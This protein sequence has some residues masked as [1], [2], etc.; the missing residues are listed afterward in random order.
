MSV[1]AAI[2]FSLYFNATSLWCCRDV[3]EKGCTEAVYS[4]HS[5]PPS[6]LLSLSKEEGE[7]LYIRVSKVEDI[8]FLRM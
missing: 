3:D 5:T 4:S 6:Q 7:L 8:S 1:V 2:R